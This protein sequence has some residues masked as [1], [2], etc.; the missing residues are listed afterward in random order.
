[1]VK[2]KIPGFSFR[3]R[4]AKRVWVR[5]Q[6]IVAALAPEDRLKAQIGE[7]LQQARDQVDPPLEKVPPEDLRIL[8]MAV[9]WLL[10]GLAAPEGEKAGE[11]QAD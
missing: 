8:E 9:Y 1:M 6:E 3:S 7:V 4:W 5:V 10:S 11:S 2:A